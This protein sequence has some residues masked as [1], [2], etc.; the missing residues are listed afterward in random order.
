M[1]LLVFIFWGSIPCQCLV[2]LAA[3]DS[4]ERI[5]YLGVVVVNCE[6]RPR[7]GRAQE[8]QPHENKTKPEESL[9]N[10]SESKGLHWLAYVFCCFDF[11]V[12]YVFEL[13]VWF[14]FYVLFFVSNAVVC[15]FVGFLCLSSVVPCLLAYVSPKISCAFSQL[16]CIFLKDILSSDFPIKQILRSSDKSK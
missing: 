5:G 2:A 1:Y 6:P 8:N 16:S 15:S 14:F 7:P 10:S 3:V 13:C 12:F 11:F 9:G 4:L